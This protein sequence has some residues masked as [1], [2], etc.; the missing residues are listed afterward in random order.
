MLKYPKLNI[1][2]MIIRV[3][4]NA[5]FAFNAD[6]SQLEYTHFLIDQSKKISANSL[7]LTS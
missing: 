1:D 7:D 6:S 5:S 3:Y 4:A 2:S